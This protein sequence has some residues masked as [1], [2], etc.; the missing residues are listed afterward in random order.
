MMLLSFLTKHKMAEQHT[1]TSSAKKNVGAAKA[2]L[3]SG[4]GNFALFAADSAMAD[5]KNGEYSLS[6]QLLDAGDYAGAAAEAAGPIASTA[7]N[8]ASGLAGTWAAGAAI[9]GATKVLAGTALAASA[10]AWIAPVAAVAGIVA[11][12]AAGYAGYSIANQFLSQKIKN[13]V[14]NFAR[15][16][17]DG[18]YA[19][20]DGETAFVT[21]RAQAAAENQASP[22]PQKD[23]PATRSPNP[24]EKNP[25]PAEQT[26]SRNGTP[27]IRPAGD[28]SALPK[29]AAPSVAPTL[30]TQEP[31]PVHARQNASPPQTQAGAAP[32]NETKV[33]S[34]NGP[35]G[36]KGN[37][38]PTTSYAP[39]L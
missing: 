29:H 1:L 8:A 20:I 34:T 18:D 33:A 17:V 23:A 19:M 26:I 25:A 27:E 37:T 3:W 31:V 10:P 12:S 16:V 2:T 30:P 4:A 9:I 24:P 6:K 14:R 5:Y 32:P 21:Q 7:V 38:G 11:I 15:K 28:Y 13:N 35:P 36:T 39:P 22:P